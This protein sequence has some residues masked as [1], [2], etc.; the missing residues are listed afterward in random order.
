M[1]TRVSSDK[2]L[3]GLV[4]VEYGYFEDDRGWFTEFFKRSAFDEF[5]LPASF[6]QINRSFS[7][8]RGTIR[9]L[10]LQLPPME[11]GK[12]VCCTKGSIF[13]V[14]VDVDKSSPTFGRWASYELSSNNRK[15]LWIPGRYAHGFQTLE[16]GTEVLYLTTNEYA[17]DLERNIFWNDSEI[18]IKW[19][20]ADP[21]LSPRDEIAPLLSDVILE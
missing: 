15:A 14:A 17:P 7:E 9:G 16:E 19:P 8:N 11:Q 5:G 21:L 20:I 1:P 12:F 2:L 6:R 18:G 3:T 13:D 4:L 10:H